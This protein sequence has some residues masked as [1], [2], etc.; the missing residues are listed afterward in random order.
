MIAFIASTPFQ[1]WN[2]IVMK[3]KLFRDEN[4][5]IYIIDH[6][7]DYNVIAERLKKEQVFED[8]FACQ[9]KDF[10]FV[11]QKNPFVRKLIQACHFIGWRG[12]MKK[13]FPVNKKYSKVIIA[14]HDSVRTIMVC[15][16]KKYNPDLEA[17]FFEDGAYDYLWN[18]H[19]KHTGLKYWFGKLVGINYDHTDNIK[20]DYVLC[21]ECVLNSRFEL[22]KIPNIDIDKDKDLIQIINRVF[23]YKPYN[24]SSKMVYLYQPLGETSTNETNALIKRIADVF[25]K[26]NVILKDHPRLPAKSSDIEKIP[27]EKECLWECMVMNNDFSNKILITPFSTASYT[28]KFLFGKEPTIIYLYEVLQSSGMMPKDKEA[29]SA[30]VNK[31]K[32]CYSDPN[33]VFVPKTEEELF[34]Y[35]EKCVK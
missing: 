25:G 23:D 14:S 13:R 21:P 19:G 28:S 18:V 7:A 20:K 35:L 2:A 22:L 16:M 26:E 32:E 29:F 1:I 27:K 9:T 10:E 24:I 6:F 5:D 11:T 4:S 30:F 33:K 34:N 12:Y 8:V 3:E 31:L 15:K 17:L